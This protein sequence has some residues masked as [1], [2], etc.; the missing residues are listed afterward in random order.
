MKKDK[1]FVHFNTNDISIYQLEQKT[2]RLLKKKQV[3]FNETLVNNELLKKIDDFLDEL[4]DVVG[5]VD[6]N[7][8]RLYATGIFQEFSQEEQMQL[9]IHIFVVS[10]LYFNIVPPEIPSEMAGYFVY[11]GFM[12]F[13]I[14]TRY[15]NRYPF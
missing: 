14:C 8:V 9:V 5:V 13:D 15:P 11:K 10:G 6:N 7:R 4:R 12:P 3:F 1:I 2:F